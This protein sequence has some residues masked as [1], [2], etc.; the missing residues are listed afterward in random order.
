[1]SATLIADVPES[2]TQDQ[3]DWINTQAWV[4]LSKIR[5]PTPYDYEDLVSEGFF[6]WTKARDTF[7]PEHGAVFHAWFNFI[8]W[9]H[10]YDLVYFSYKKNSPICVEDLSM[11][12]DR[13]RNTEREVH[14]RDWLDVKLSVLEKQYLALSLKEKAREPKDFRVRVRVALNIPE[15]IE[16]DLRRSIRKIILEF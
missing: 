1:M 9:R 10:L 3:I 4:T 7:E 12:Q 8:L 13:P 15:R 16:M 14:F 11:F 2:P 6:A 5:K